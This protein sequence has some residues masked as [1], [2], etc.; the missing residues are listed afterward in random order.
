MRLLQAI[1]HHPSTKALALLVWV[2]WPTQQLH[3]Q[4]DTVYNDT[5]KARNIKELTVTSRR[6]ATRRLSGAQNGFSM[7][8]DELFKAACCNLGESF[9]T[10]PS[11]DV[12]YSDAATGAKQIRLLGLSGAMGYAGIRVNIGRM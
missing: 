10:N 4:T 2:L 5:V 8:R 12:N 9:T 11:V 3:S 7:S 6:S 1:D